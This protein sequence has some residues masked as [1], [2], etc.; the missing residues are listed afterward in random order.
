[1]NLSGRRNDA[2]ASLTS[3]VSVS[4]TALALSKTCRR[5]QPFGTETDPVFMAW[6]RTTGITITE[7]QIIG[8][9]QYPVTLDGAET[10]TNKTIISPLGLTSSDVGLGDVDNTSD[11][12]KPLS[13]AMIAS[14]ALKEDVANKSTDITTDGAS[15][16]MYP[17]VMAVKTYVDARIMGIVTHNDTSGKQGGTTNEFY[18]LTAAQHVIATQAANAS[19]AGYLTASDWN[20][21]NSGLGG[22]TIHVSGTPVANQISI[23]SAVDTIKGMAGLTYDGTDLVVSGN[24]RATGE[25]SAFD[26]GAPLNFWD[27]MPIATDSTLGGIII[28]ANLTIDENGVLNADGGSGTAAWGSISGSISAQTDLQTALGLKLNTSTYTDAGVLAKLLN[29]DGP[30]SGLNAD[31]LDGLHAAAFGLVNANTTGSSG[32]VLTANFCIMQQSGKLVIKYAASNPAS[33]TV[34]LSITSAGLVT[35]TNEVTAFGTP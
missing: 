12:S 10:L 30:S 1:M 7:S 15:N 8:G 2:I 35:A 4:T 17:S 6:D 18:H 13:N 34:I 5:P 28:G 21:F 33:G 11:A 14:L 20:T 31:L 19:R 23:W 16:T 9:I 29:V 3:Q 22:S 32:S 27:D 25:V 24:I 26:S